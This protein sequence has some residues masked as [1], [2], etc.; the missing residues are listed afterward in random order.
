[1]KYLSTELHNAMETY[2]KAVKN[3][4]HNK[5]LGASVVLTRLHQLELQI[6]NEVHNIFNP[7]DEGKPQVKQQ[8]AN[9]TPPVKQ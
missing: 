2:T 6:A 9:E 7:P 4:A 5:L 8:P 1:M 3:K